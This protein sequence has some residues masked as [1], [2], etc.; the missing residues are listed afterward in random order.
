MARILVR[1]TDGSGTP[2]SATN[3]PAIP[4]GATGY[5]AIEIRRAE[6]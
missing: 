6:G 5:H 3:R 4:D 1:A 2:Q